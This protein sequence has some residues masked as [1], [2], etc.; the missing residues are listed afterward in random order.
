MEITEI[1][2]NMRRIAFHLKRL[3]N[4]QTPLPLDGKAET[5]QRVEQ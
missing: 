2:I 3:Q 5:S 4:A 1:S